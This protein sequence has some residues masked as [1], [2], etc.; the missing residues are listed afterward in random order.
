MTGEV[1][2]GKLAMT[3]C[4]NDEGARGADRL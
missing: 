2:E 4:A 1:K 3:G